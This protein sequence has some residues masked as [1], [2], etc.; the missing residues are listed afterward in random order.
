MCY[1][2]DVAT[3]PPDNTDVARLEKDLSFFC[4]FEATW[5]D[6]GS[7]IEALTS[8]EGQ[9]VIADVA[10]YATGGYVRLHYDVGE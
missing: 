2:F 5:D 8:P 4:V 6:E 3:E 10:N 1:S 9:A 7:M